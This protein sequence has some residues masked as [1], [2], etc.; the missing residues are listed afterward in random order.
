MRSVCLG[1]EATWPRS[2]LASSETRAGDSIPVYIQPMDINRWSSS[3][4]KQ[5]LRLFLRCD[6]STIRINLL[7]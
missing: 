2:E 7:C 3:S 4:F 6:I 1:R 5:R